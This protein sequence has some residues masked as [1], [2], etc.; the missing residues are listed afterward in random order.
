[1]SDAPPLLAGIETEARPKS[2]GP[3]VLLVMVG[4]LHISTLLSSETHVLGGERQDLA[5]QFLPWLQVGY[6]S[7]GR[8]EIP[9]TNPWA[10]GGYPF[11]ANWQSA[12]FYPV[13]WLHLILPTGLAV[14]LFL[15]IH[16]YLAGVFTWM[17]ARARG[18]SDWPAVVAGTTFMLAGPTYGHLFPGHMTWMSAIAWFPLML[19]AIDRIVRGDGLVPVRCG[20]VLAVAVGMQWL[21]GYPQPAYISLVCAV[22][23]AVYLLACD[24][25]RVLSKLVIGVGGTTLGFGIAWVQIGPGLAM[26]PETY[27][28]AGL[29]IEIAGTYSVPAM[30]FWLSLSPHAFGDLV[31]TRYLGEWLIWEVWPFIGLTV[32]CLASSR[33]L[34]HPGKAILAA[35]AIRLLVGVALGPK[36]IPF[37]WMFYHLPGMDRFRVPGRW[38]MPV[39]LIAG[40]MAARTLDDILK[41][42][43]AGRLSLS[44][45]R[46]KW[47]LAAPWIAVAV[48]LGVWTV[49][50]LSRAGWAVDGWAYVLKQVAQGGRSLMPLNALTPQSLASWLQFSG[51]RSAEC[52]GLCLT[53]LLVVLWPAVRFPSRR[54]GGLLVALAVGELLLFASRLTTSFTFTEQPP[55]SWRQAIAA[56]PKGTRAI[57]R[58]DHW[59]NRGADLGIAGVWGYDPVVL[60]RTAEVMAVTQGIPPEQANQ[61]SFGGLYSPLLGKL[62]NVSLVLEIDRRKGVA[63]AA[64]VNDGL[65]EAWF[66]E[67]VHVLPEKIAR[68][69]WLEDPA[70]DLRHSVA[71]ELDT[72]RGSAARSGTEAAVERSTTSRLESGLVLDRLV[73][74]GETAKTY[75]LTAGSNGVVVISAAYARGWQYRLTPLDGGQA[76]WWAPALAADHALIGIPIPGPGRYRIELR[77]RPVTYGG[78]WISLGAVLVTLSIAAS[79]RNGR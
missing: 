31:T 25:R 62:W 24:R 47:G 46:L 76:A 56:V 63:T 34:L 9:W 74:E 14:N 20:L 50:A 10:F 7:V 27:R 8:G 21:A 26:G 4:L 17:L 55:D 5:T 19:W 11:V 48:P 23:F 6:D 70:T 41:S 2:F 49:G 38:L 15:S 18:I 51:Q 68:L 78:P 43:S 33:L 71:I 67:D 1:M 59:Q 54:R 36:H 64:R 66:A 29:P 75:R 72:R 44:P 58:D 57:I 52:L 42:A 30:N 22:V 69:A 60:R 3:W 16:V 28:S 39:A 53:V 61:D 37:D 32:I 77:F 73:L 79:Y 45:T 12:I 65:G 40:L 13:N 35:I